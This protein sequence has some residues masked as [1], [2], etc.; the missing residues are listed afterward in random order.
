MFAEPAGAAGYAGFQKA[1]G[2]G[3]FGKNDVVTVLVTGNGLK[4]VASA[5]RAVSEAHRVEPSLDDV[6]R[7]VSE[8][9]GS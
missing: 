6:T 8:I 5:R 3:L 1:A 7:V 2:D 4:D 9:F